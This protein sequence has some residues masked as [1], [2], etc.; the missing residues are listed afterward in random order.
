VRGSPN[1]PPKLNRYIRPVDMVLIDA[2]TYVIPPE[3]WLQVHLAD[4]PDPAAVGSTWFARSFELTPPK[5]FP[6][7]NDQSI[8]LVP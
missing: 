5:P 3:G 6:S 2:G 7:S 4:L 8:T 1:G